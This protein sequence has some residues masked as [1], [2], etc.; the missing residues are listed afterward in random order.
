VNKALAELYNTTFIE[1]VVA[2][3]DAAS[4]ATPAG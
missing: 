3:Q 1:Q 2:A 4:E